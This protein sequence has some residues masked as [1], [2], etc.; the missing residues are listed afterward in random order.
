MNITKIILRNWACD[1]IVLTPDMYRNLRMYLFLM[2]LCDYKI[3][4]F[5][6]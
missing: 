3:A 2:L 5:D 6:T 1:I 4:N